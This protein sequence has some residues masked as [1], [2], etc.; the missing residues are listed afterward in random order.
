MPL[1]F[2]LVGLPDTTKFLEVRD[3][4]DGSINLKLFTELFVFWGVTTDELKQINF[5]INSESI[6]NEDINYIIKK[7]E[8][9][10]IF[11]YT[12]CDELKNKLKD[13]F[14]KNGGAKHM[15]QPEL[16]NEITEILP[17]IQ[18]ELTDD[19]INEMNLKSIKLFSDPDFKFLICIFVKRPELF[20]TLSQYVQNCDIIKDSPISLEDKDIER[21]QEL[22]NNIHYLN[23]GINYAQ[24]MDR[25]I[26]L[27]GHLNL[28]LRS[29]LCEKALLQ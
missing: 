21:Y 25:L 23:I 22:A 7:D 9:A 26:R 29:L 24:I 18:P 2:K 14:I 3:E 5:I 28:T 13:I 11:V 20:S 27:K 10:I 16:E 4:F 6:K 17:E 15:I 19:I 1:V 12:K 8:D